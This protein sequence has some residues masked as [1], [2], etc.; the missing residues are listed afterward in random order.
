MNEASPLSA[1]KATR[2]TDIDVYEL[3]RRRAAGE[4][5]N[6]V[7]VREAKELA[8]AKLEGVTVIPLSEFEA[9]WPAELSHLKEQELILMC[10]S[11]GRSARVQSYLIACGFTKTRNLIGGILAWSDAIDRTVQKY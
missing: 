10:R 1:P 11:G 9:R 2:P 3:S 4:R 7:D 6:V 5:L 8:I